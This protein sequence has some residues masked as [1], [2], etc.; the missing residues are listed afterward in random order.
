[1]P[2]ETPQQQQ[3]QSPD[4]TQALVPVRSTPMREMLT[5]LKETGD[6]SLFQQFATDII[7]R[8]LAV[9]RF[10]QDSQLARVFAASGAFNGINGTD[11]GV[12]LA[13]TKI[14]LG[15][16]W[17][18]E[19][20]DAMKSVFFINGRPSVES[21]YLAAQ[22]QNAGISWDIEWDEDN[23]KRCTGCHLH[24]KRWNPDTKKFDPIM[25]KVN[26][27]E[28]QAVV[29][30]TKMDADTAMV[31]ENGKTI[32]LSEKFNYQSW[33]GDMYFARC[34][35][36]ARTRYCPNVLSGVMTREEAEDAG[37]GTQQVTGTSRGAE[38]AALAS[39]T[40]LDEIGKKLEAAKPKPEPAA[41]VQPT[42]SS[43]AS[44]VS[45][46]AATQAAAPPPAATAQPSNVVSI[47]PDKAPWAA[48][49]GKERPTMVKLYS[50]IAQ[51]VG[52]PAFEEIMTR[53]DFQWSEIPKTPW[54]SPKVLACYREMEA[55]VKAP[56]VETAAVAETEDKPLF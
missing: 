45:D 44:P 7:Q 14:Q 25:G 55:R 41:P 19:I 40:K 22:M 56:K 6:A 35:S 21:S 33:P 53:H 37:D 3:Q 36:R 23:T 16:S 2:D 30:F 13:M 11:Q 1:M 34:V 43:G 5:I 48:V 42:V 28:R 26:G 46:D 27:V 17:N 18:M 4:Q 10:G 49:A 31:F 52:K 51:A 9:A 29:S 32:K 54:D 15:R 47:S 50:E 38:R 39:A 12:A 24:L 20:A 8:E